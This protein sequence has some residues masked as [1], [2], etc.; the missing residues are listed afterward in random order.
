MNKS[1]KVGLLVN[2]VAGLGATVALRGSDGEARQTTARRLGGTPRAPTRATDFLNQLGH[3]GADLDW[4][5]WYGLG[6]E[7]LQDLGFD[8]KAVGTAATPS[9]AED[10]QA[11][12]R[13][14]CSCDIDLLLFVGGDGTAV[15][16]LGAV[17]PQQL[18]LGV[19][20]GVKMHSGVFAVSPQAAAKVLGDLLSGHLVE[21]IEADVV[22][23]LP[24]QRSATSI[25]VE[26]F[27]VLKVPQAGGFLQH[28]KEGGRES[29]PLVVEEICADIL[30]SLASARPL[31][32]GPGSTLLAIKQA[33]GAPEPTLRGIDVLTDTY[34]W[35]TNAT[36]ALLEKLTE[37]WLVIS[38]T[39]HQGF[40][41]GRGNLELS[42]QFLQGL[43]PDRLVVV[44][45]RTKISSL[46][47][48]PL[49]IDTGVSEQ[50]Q[51]FAG[52]VEITAGYQ[53]QLV[54]RVQ[55]ASRIG[56]S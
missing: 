55:A 18:C 47:G 20:A 25:Q 8:C 48:R 12:V 11:C 7:C 30:E 53:D 44:S 15:D 36:A 52:L 34:Q 56:D 45:S 49:L 42:P 26:H 31:V 17:K 32:L 16:V 14:L 6:A 41:L 4:F 10:S 23:Y 39:R 27:G 38:F 50:D 35:Q 40:L 51:R 24:A 54:Y 43:Q 29:E 19:P 21:A 1:F 37:P 9:T 33:L 3:V 46:E 13:Q 2:P 5:S 28:T 22:D